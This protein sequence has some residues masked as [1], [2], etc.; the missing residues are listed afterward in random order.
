[1]IRWLSYTIH[2]MKTIFVAEFI[3]TVTICLHTKFHGLNSDSSLE[4]MQAPRYS[5]TLHKKILDIVAYFSVICYHSAFQFSKLSGASVI[6]VSQV[7]PSVMLLLPI[8]G[9]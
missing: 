4:F 6:S 9:N 1:M 2:D 5:F 7:H 3:G 8:V